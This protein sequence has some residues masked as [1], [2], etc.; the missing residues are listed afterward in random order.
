MEA[1]G[2][3]G[4]DWSELE[5]ILLLIWVDSFEEAVELNVDWSKEYIWF[6]YEQK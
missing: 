6:I 4:G 3:N 5:L 1:N 2:F